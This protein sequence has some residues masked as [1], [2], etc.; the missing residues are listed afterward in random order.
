VALAASLLASAFA[1]VPRWGAAGLAMAHGIAYSVAAILLAVAVPFSARRRVDPA[2][3]AQPLL[4]HLTT[5]PETLHFLNGQVAYMKGQGFSVGAVSAPLAELERFGEA[6]GI[7]TWS[8]PL[9]RRISPIQD[10]V[11]IAKLVSLLR[12]I[13][14]TVL[15]AHTPKGGLVGM[16]AGALANV[17]VRIYH[18][19]G[20]PLETARG[21]KRFLLV[22]SDRV[23][24]ALAHRVLAVS[25]SLLGAALLHGLVDARKIG[26]PAGG[27]I[28]GVDADRAF[29][30]K[31]HRS[32]GPRVRLRLGL[33]ADSLVI[34]FVGRICRD[35]GM[36]ELEAAWRAV[37]ARYA[38][39]HL[40]V[41]G[42]TD[43]TD[44]LPDEVLQSLRSDPRVHLVGLDWDVAPYMAAMNVLVLPTH[45]EGLGNVLLEAG[46]MGV[47]V[48][49]TRTT[50]CV[51]AV[52]D[53]RTGLL[54]PP[55]D[56]VALAS[57]ISTY[58]SSKALRLQ[59][60]AA[61]REHILARFAQPVVWRAM[62]EEYQRAL[63][64]SRVGHKAQTLVQ[65]ARPA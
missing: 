46:G 30:P 37:R 26:V 23:A 43:D 53:G 63:A 40:L 14:P 13:R 44:P 56:A 55:R 47:P 21:L 20:L 31:S 49:A 10:L 34:G 52:V 62:A 33:A 41:V 19:H 28:N 12:R 2:T 6:Q 29:S 60:G 36:V 48:V 35:K 65:V 61:A 42:P 22:A 24:C 54:V 8:I 39:S 7:P 16:I 1:L 9:T 57:A 4:L 51:D 58:L 32:A 11:A 27:S 3:P 50:G 45:R 18:L 17:P 64:R 5:V 25:P 59:H 38:S 15:H